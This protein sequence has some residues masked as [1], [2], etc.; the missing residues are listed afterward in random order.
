MIWHCPC[1]NFNL[2]EEI[3]WILSVCP[4]YGHLFTE[5]QCVS[6]LRTILKV[7]FEILLYS[8]LSILLGCPML[9]ICCCSHIFYFNYSS[10][11]FSMFKYL[12]G[13]NILKDSNLNCTRL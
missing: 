5:V 8:S 3:S 11:S 7:L 10:F 12:E 2:F 6:F 9:E 13:F 1:G 4:K